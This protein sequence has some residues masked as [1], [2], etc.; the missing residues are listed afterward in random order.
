MAFHETNQLRYYSFDL[1]ADAPVQQG[2]FTRKGGVSPT[3]WD[4]LNTG[5]MNGDLRENVIENRRRI[6]STFDRKVETIF[7]VW[8]VHGK[9]VIATTEAR[10]LD[11][12]HQ[13]ADAILTDRDNIT[14]F[15][16]FG[17]CLPIY[18]F[19]P[20]KAGDW[21]RACWL[22]GHSRKNRPGHSASHAA[23]QYNS[24]PVD[25]LAGIG[26]SICG[27]HYE[28]GG[29]ALDIV[30]KSFLRW[31][32]EVLSCKRTVKYY[33]DLWRANYLLLI[34]AGSEPRAYPDQWYLYG[35]EYRGL[36]FSP[37][38]TR[39]NRTFW[40]ASCAKIR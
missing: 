24:R 35:W 37:G 6:F 36:V 5:G 20:I 30:Q 31:E 39:E 21:N 38:R 40:G 23:G 16:R 28:F 10:R 19:D 11:A 9:E 29:K 33:F 17:D 4:S 8:Q 32:A 18:F 1:L 12:A 26:P 2:I 25:I 34:Q 3:P 7:D 27:E 13:K 14:L 22:A 15:M